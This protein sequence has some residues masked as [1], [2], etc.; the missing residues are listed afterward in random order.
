MSWYPDGVSGPK[1][2][3]P[4]CR[5]C[6]DRLAKVERAVLLPL[7]LCLDPSDPLTSGIPQAV[8]R[9]IDPEQAAKPGMTQAEIAR[10]RRARQKLRQEVMSRL[11]VP[12]EPIDRGALPGFG[13][14]RV[15]GGR[16]AIM[17]PHVDELQAI[18]NK[19]IRV[20]VWFMRDGQFIESDTEVKTHIVQIDTVQNIASMVRGGD[21]LDVFP[22]IR[23]TLRTAS[24]QLAAH[25]ALFELWDRLKFFVSVVPAPPATH[26]A[27]DE[28]PSSTSPAGRP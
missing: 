28:D 14:E 2:K 8:M 20:A 5:A 21:A 11:F 4:S 13:P 15:P 25:I 26:I 16:L 22:G 12:Q 7:A 18:G 27:T 6:Q 17:G 1:A 9:S 10:E 19:F 23:I 24:D 3:A